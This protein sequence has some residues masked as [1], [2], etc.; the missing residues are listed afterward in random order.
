MR[1]NPSQVLSLAAA[2]VTLALLESVGWGAT[3][4]IDLSLEDYALEP[5]LGG[6][7]V[8]ISVVDQEGGTTVE[9]VTLNVRLD[10]GLSPTMDP[11]PRITAVDMLG[12]SATPTIFYNQ[13]NSPVDPDGEPDPWPYYESRSVTTVGPPVAA[14]GLLAIVT[15][16]T[17]GVSAGQWD[18][19]LRD[20]ADVATEFPG[21]T[22]D[23][24]PGVL[25][26]VPEPSTC[27]LL[28]VAILGL[29]GCCARRRVRQ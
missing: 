12:D 15:F 17:S 5:N 20:P 7:Q 22:L 9:G 21:V 13:A 28:L 23:L 6:Q 4:G 10:D 19:I 27:G 18:L 29:L 25:S 3:L 11:A 2:L 1:T 14:D 24:T 26:I 16:D 8:L